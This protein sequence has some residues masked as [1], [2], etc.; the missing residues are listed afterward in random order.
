MSRLR[1]VLFGQPHLEFDDELLVLKRRKSLALLGYL[2]LSDRPHNRQELAAMFWPET[3]TSHALGSLRTTLSEAAQA[4]GIPTLTTGGDTVSFHHGNCRCDAWEFIRN[5]REM[6]REA[7]AECLRAAVELYSDAFM[8]GF[9]LKDSV[10]FDD[11][12]IAVA[13]SCRRDFSMA[14]ARLTEILIAGN[15]LDEALAVNQKW[16]MLDSLNEEAH[17]SYMTVFRMVG[18]DQEAIRQ[19][20]VMT[21][22][23][24][25]NL[26]QEPNEESN[27]II[28]EIGDTVSDDRVG[29]AVLPLSVLRMDE[30]SRS[31]SNGVTSALISGLSGM[32]KLNVTSHSSS[33]RYENQQR[34]RK[35][36]SRELDVSYLVEGSIV[37][38]AS[39]VEIA[40]K[41]FE[42][43]SNS[44][45]WNRT[46]S[47][48]LSGIFELQK[49]IAN[50]ISDRFLEFAAPGAETPTDA[51]QSI[52][53]KLMERYFR[54][55][56]ISNSYQEEDLKEAALEFREILEEAPGF[57]PA[58]TS[59]ADN[60]M[61]L[62][63]VF[64]SP[65]PLDQV[66][67]EV[68]SLVTRALE[69]APE[70]LHTL[71][72]AGEY[73]SDWCWDWRHAENCYSRAL[74]LHP[75]DAQ[76]HYFMGLY[77]L[78]TGHP[79]ESIGH[80]KKARML[81]PGDLGPVWTLSRW[82]LRAGD[83]RTSEEYLQSILNMKPGHW[84]ALHLLGVNSLM[85]NRYTQAE[86][87]LKESISF[88]EEH[89]ETYISLGVLYARTGRQDKTREIEQ[90]LRRKFALDSTT[91][92]PLAL[93]EWEMGE[94]D[95]ADRLLRDS[96]RKRDIAIP[97]ALYFP[98]YRRLAES[99]IWKEVIGPIIP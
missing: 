13:E 39:S 14:C 84:P 21:L 58:I 44:I 48:S 42:A 62:T 32:K 67:P 54:A 78:Q 6:N 1:L 8:R 77:Q 65:Y 30:D 53:E 86:L 69:L 66:R 57:Y 28:D 51:V 17:Q 12:Q 49:S 20:Q 36:I 80:L 5:C 61:S 24:N 68:D 98:T 29:I 81:N 55:E 34:T 10:A 73:Y 16:T 45:V 72:V 71:L 96:V 40:L 31:L 88:C 74:A 90:N 26:E 9:S 15:Q 70:D 56:L 19:Y 95:E 91:L 11:W 3:D 37:R 97:W 43:V 99:L 18:Q 46:Y 41:L 60:L 52:D 92:L 85:Q 33:S 79:D 83:Y 2:A 64:T 7:D 76:V 82:Y 47:G 50:E 27:R 35:Q 63:S 59:L 38:R 23:L 22:L 25:Q 93:L 75:G 89:P 4:G 94:P 87:L